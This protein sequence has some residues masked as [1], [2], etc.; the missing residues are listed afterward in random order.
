MASMSSSSVFGAAHILIQICLWQSY[1]LCTSDEEEHPSLVMS[2][3]E[4]EYMS[5]DE[6]VGASS[7]KGVSNS[8]DSSS[9][10]ISS[11]WGMQEHF[12]QVRSARSR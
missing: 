12:L 3:E 9:K 7:S 8:G 6:F 1:Y 11:K 5:D 2:D 10:R 4:D